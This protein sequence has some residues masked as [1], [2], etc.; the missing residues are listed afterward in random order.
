MDKLNTKQKIALLTMDALLLIELTMCVYYSYQD[1]A[2]MPYL[3]MRAYV[4]LCLG[5][6][7]FFKFLIRKMRTRNVED[8]PA[9]DN[10]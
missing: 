1:K 4:P 10:A 3:F 8:I 5:T 6:L 7:F 9:S 2:N